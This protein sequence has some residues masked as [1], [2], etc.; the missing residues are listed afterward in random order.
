MLCFT[1]VQKFLV[2]QSA[3]LL[4]VGKTGR[5][6]AVWQKDRSPGHGPVRK[7]GREGRKYVADERKKKENVIFWDYRTIFYDVKM[8]NNRFFSA[9]LLTK[10]TDLSPGK[11]GLHIIYNKRGKVKKGY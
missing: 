3:G 9:P 6:L 5:G 4:I 8:K 10:K 2:W 7:P 11:S 1:K